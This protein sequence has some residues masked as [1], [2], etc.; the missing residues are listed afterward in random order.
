MSVVLIILGGLLV[1]IGIVGCVVPVIPGPPVSYISLI[2]LSFAY[3]WKVFT[4]TF[5]IVMGVLTVIAT[6]LDYILPVY[7]P[8]RYGGSKY[9]VWGS[10]LGMLAGMIF[11]PPFGLIIGTLAGAI[12]AELIFNENKKAALKS[13]LGVFL[14]TIAAMFV[15]ISV[16]GVIGFYFFKAVMRG[17]V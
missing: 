5:L 2:L 6:V 15:K 7:L 1:V 10:I 8:K 3:H 13:G 11:F 4:P 12:L 17:P 16:S 9:G 14:G